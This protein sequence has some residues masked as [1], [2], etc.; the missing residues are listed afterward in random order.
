MA[1][2]TVV[3]VNAFNFNVNKMWKY[4]KLFITMANNGARDAMQR[5]SHTIMCQLNMFVYDGRAL[6]RMLAGQPTDQLYRSNQS[7]LIYR[8]VRSF[9]PH[10]TRNNSAAAAVATFRTKQYNNQNAENG[11]WCFAR[12]ALTQKMRRTNAGKEI[13]VKD[14]QDENRK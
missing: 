3:V 4:I 13:S 8:N 10:Y 12:C 6:V 11:A 9:G 5:R 14:I 7:K 2:V 1:G